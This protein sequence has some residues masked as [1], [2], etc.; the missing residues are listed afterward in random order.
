[1]DST[2]ASGL[3]RLTVKSSGWCSMLADVDNDGWKDL[4]TTHSHVD[5]RIG[6]FEAIAWKQPNGLFVNDGRGHF[7][8]RTADSG[9]GGAAAAH[10]GCA[11]A[12]L[13]GDGRLDLVVLA[14]GDRAELWKNESAPRNAWLIVH[15]IGTKSNRD[16]IGARVI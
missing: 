15:P 3:A 11:A 10:R 12:D 1:V 4:F 2:Y 13:D 6:D 9:L 16:G 14:L 8:D 5:D 7:V